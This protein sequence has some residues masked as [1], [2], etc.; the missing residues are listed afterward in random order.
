MKKN[1]IYKPPLTWWIAVFLLLAAINL[2]SCRSVQYVP[3]RSDMVVM[4]SIVIRDS[5]VY[6]DRVN[7]RDSVAVR[8]SVV[9]VLNDNG[10]MLRK[11]VYKYRD[12]YSS[13]VRDMEDLQ[14]RY[15]ELKATKEER[16]EVPVP[17]QQKLSW[18]QRTKM[19]LPWLIGGIVIGIVLVFIH[20]KLKPFL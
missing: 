9:L 17:V 2:C 6:Q 4:D 13:L 1:E 19:C 14:K 16:V 8:D 12:R 3:V 7:M 18:W 15:D 5:I 11:E 10:Q 20:R